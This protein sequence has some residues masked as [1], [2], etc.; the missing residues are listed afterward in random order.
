MSATHLLTQQILKHKHLLQ[1][2]LDEY[3]ERTGYHGAVIATKTGELLV[4]STRLDPELHFPAYAQTA[5]RFYQDIAEFQGE[6]G[7]LLIEGKKYKLFIRKL[8][9]CME[10]EDFHHLMIAMS[11]N[12]F[13]FRQGIKR[14]LKQLDVFLG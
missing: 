2:I 10:P 9:K 8:P 1:M 13:Y 14:L 7:D 12:A 5:A 6:P 4:T 3:M 11:P